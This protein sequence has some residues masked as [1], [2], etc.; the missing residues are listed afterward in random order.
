MNFLLG[1]LVFI[2]GF[3]LGVKLFQIKRSKEIISEN[4]QSMDKDYKQKNT[5]GVLDTKDKKQIRLEPS[6]LERE[7]LYGE[8]L[9]LLF[10]IGQELSGSATLQ[11]I[12]RIVVEN[13]KKI[14][15]VEKCAIL[16]LSSTTDRLCIEYSFGLDKDE[17]RN[18]DIKKDESISGK[19][20]TNKE[21]LFIK[22]IEDDYWIK[23]TNKEEYYTKSLISVPL[24]VRNKVFGVLNV[25]NKL[26]GSQFTEDDLRLIKGMAAQ[27]AAAIQNAKLYEELKESYLRTI[28]ALA[29][30][31]DAKDHYTHRHSENVTRYA[32]AIAEELKLTELEIENIR[33]AGLLH[34]IGKIG[35]EDGI[36]SSPR[37][38]TEEEYEQIKKHCATGQEIIS[39][40]P[41]LKEVGLYVRHH[42]E[43]LNG[44]GYPDG[45]KGYEIELPARIL[46]VCDGFDAMTSHR[47]Y[48]KALSIKEACEELKKNK[49]TQFDP[50]I[51]D[52]FLKILK[53]NPDIMK[54]ET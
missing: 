7:I 48:R 14:F 39:S 23:A 49:G 24:S 13:I 42:H 1:V 38:L 26:G 41:F 16:L 36:L 35:I 47:P 22:N 53:N 45:K 29:T 2:T 9:N 25:N 34:D 4:R 19:V 11:D 33:R 43:R 8:E 15:N 50:E 18:T 51:V 21:M 54:E 37:K 27:A 30:A 3:A 40:L 6:V 44:K 28:M 31:L 5:Q 32:V 17:I 20:F 46:A 12:C 52:T 10:K